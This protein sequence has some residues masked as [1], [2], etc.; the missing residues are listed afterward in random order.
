MDVSAV[1]VSDGGRMARPAEAGRRRGPNRGGTVEIHGPGW[2]LPVIPADAGGLHPPT[3]S[4][5]GEAGGHT[6]LVSDVAAYDP[7]RH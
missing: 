5:I 7:D 1:K 2:A 4:S 6:A 3:G